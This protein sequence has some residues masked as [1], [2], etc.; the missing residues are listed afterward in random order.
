MSLCYLLAQ[1]GAATSPPTSP[2]MLAVL[3]QVSVVERDFGLSD[4][5]YALVTAY[6]SLVST[7]A[8]N[9]AHSLDD[10]IQELSDAQKH[11]TAVRDAMAAGQP[12]PDTGTIQAA[13][14]VDDALAWGVPLT[15]GRA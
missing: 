14:G 1:H 11:L 5:L 10:A 4:T 9:H 15:E 7:L 3:A 12:L 13:I 8:A 2:V 6:T